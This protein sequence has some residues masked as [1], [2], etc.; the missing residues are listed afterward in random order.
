MQQ[1]FLS[2]S[3][4]LDLAVYHMIT[5][6]FLFVVK[7]LF[8]LPKAFLQNSLIPDLSVSQSSCVEPAVAFFSCGCCISTS[9]QTFISIDAA[10][11]EELFLHRLRCSHPQGELSV[12]DLFPPEWRIMPFVRAVLQPLLRRAHSF[13]DSEKSCLSSLCC[14]VCILEMVPSWI[15]CDT[16]SCVL[17]TYLLQP[18]YSSFPFVGVSCAPAGSWQLNPCW[19][20]QFPELHW[21]WSSP[22]TQQMLFNAGLIFHKFWMM[23]SLPANSMFYMQRIRS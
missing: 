12:R 22:N 19:K 10:L 4:I 14:C 1:T 15:L 8:L 9:R 13:L 6:T 2:A 16:C 17:Q 3:R 18:K 23:E 7:Y 11:G 21:P 5:Q 20:P